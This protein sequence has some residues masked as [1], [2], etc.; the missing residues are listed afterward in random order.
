MSHSFFIFLSY[1][2][3]VWLCMVHLVCLQLYLA[4]CLCKKIWTGTCPDLLSIL[5]VCILPGPLVMRWEEPSYL[6][7]SVSRPTSTHADI[8]GSQ[9]AHQWVYHL[10]PCRGVFTRPMRREAGVRWWPWANRSLFGVLGAQPTG[11]GSVK[12][13]IRLRDGRGKA[14]VTAACATASWNHRW[15]G[16]WTF[17]VRTTSP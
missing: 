17:P 2:H 6:C 4:A 12:T 5:P 8:K 14:C 9:E 16:R 1:L 10:S 3:P 15:S 11:S 7:R 13:A